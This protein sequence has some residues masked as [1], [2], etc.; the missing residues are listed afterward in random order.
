MGKRAAPGK[1]GRFCTKIP[2][3]RAGK[4]GDGNRGR[5]GQRRGRNGREKIREGG[6]GME[7]GRR[8]TSAC[9]PFVQ[10]CRSNKAGGKGREGKRT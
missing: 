5:P 9:K 10:S 3:Q 1:A 2:L 8:K 4:R 6:S 7:K